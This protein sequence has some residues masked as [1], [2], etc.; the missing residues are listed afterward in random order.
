MN[1]CALRQTSSKPALRQLIAELSDYI[2]PAAMSPEVDGV[3]HA[4]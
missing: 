3:L 2:W 4:E 1:G